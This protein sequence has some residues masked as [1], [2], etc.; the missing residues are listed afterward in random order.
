VIPTKLSRITASS[1]EGVP[2][3]VFLVDGNPGAKAWL[4]HAADR[5]GEQAALSLVEVQSR[6]ARARVHPDDQMRLTSQGVA[7]FSSASSSNHTNGWPG[8]QGT[9]P[10]A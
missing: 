4:V 3:W 1:T 5:Q 8:A 6:Q 2:K 10:S 7:A 9:D